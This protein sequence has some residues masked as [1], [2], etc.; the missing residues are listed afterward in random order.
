MRIKTT[1]KA[2]TDSFLLRYLLSHLILFFLPVF[3]I[4]QFAFGGYI[5][6]LEHEL[7]N[8][9]I[10]MQSQV[11]AIVDMK[12]RETDQIANNMALNTELLPY[13]VLQNN[14]R[15]YK[16][17]QA[18]ENY[19]MGNDF[20]L[21]MG[22]YIRGGDFLYASGKTYPINKIISSYYQYQDLSQDDFYNLM[23]NTTTPLLIPAQRVRFGV[24]NLSIITYITP[25][26]KSGS[27]YA[28][29]VF[30]IDESKIGSIA[31]DIFGFNNGINLIYDSSGS[32]ISSLGSLDFSPPQDIFNAALSSADNSIII[33]A[34]K[35]LVTVKHAV[36]KDWIYISL[37]PYKQAMGPAIQMRNTI[38]ILL[39][40]VSVLGILV[41]AASLN[42][43][44]KPIRKIF[45]KLDIAGIKSGNEILAIDKAIDAL[46]ID[47]TNMKKH[48]AQSNEV[49][50]QRFIR[51]LFR[52]TIPDNQS[53]YNMQTRCSVAFNG[54]I[55][56][57]IIFLI[58]NTNDNQKTSHDYIDFANS[59]SPLLCEI[60]AQ[61]YPLDV[62]GKETMPILTV[63]N[64]TSDL[65]EVADVFYSR[66]LCEN[67]AVTMG[68][69]DICK[70]P[71]EIALT[72]SQASTA[73][74]YRFVKGKNVIIHYRDINKFKSNS[75]YPKYEMQEFLKHVS[76][77]NIAGIN[78]NV[79][80]VIE[81]IKQ[82]EL[83]LFAARCLC[84]DLIN[85]I[86]KFV[87]ELNI[88]ND[89]MY[90][91]ISDVRRF[92]QSE[93]VDELGESLDDFCVNLARHISSVNNDFQTEEILAYI[94]KNYTQS[95]FSVKAMAADLNMSYSY[96]SKYFH[97]KTGCTVMEYITTLRIDK[98][99]H[100]LSTTDETI[101]NIIIS[102]GY[103]DIPNFSRK[104]KQREGV[105]PGQYRDKYRR[106]SKV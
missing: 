27:D 68:V 11:S 5:S 67:I 95:D 100:M 30:F 104:F 76:S 69:S 101:K 93:T 44:Y 14:Y 96:I 61:I 42:L 4:I 84:Y 3:L 40:I 31:N 91:R 102:A 17:C 55:Y 38:S 6:A 73:L 33:D 45:R 8:R 57:T 1:I 25:V 60:G 32:L 90:D 9:N 54:N 94:K 81:Y 58:D 70:D 13:T 35:Y 53:F 87:S 37:G 98:V 83:D 10:Y 12:M 64:D 49:L 36:Y 15:A 79:R 105:T 77:G 97:S 24:S 28:T 62:I 29:A 52:G 7:V 46:A 48:I 75:H 92:S 82:Q 80:S 41:T 22:Y 16:A 20:I 50:L 103:I 106:H 78:E 85:I 47:N 34:Q 21:E 18:V 39:A 2:H 43:N 65:R 59:I 71:M 99:K 26:S 88:H 86:I 23:E 74:A 63:L 89:I 66:F 51:D 56:A 72:Y 19:M